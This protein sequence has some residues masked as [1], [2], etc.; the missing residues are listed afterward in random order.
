MIGVEGSVKVILSLGE[1]NERE[2]YYKGSHNG[3]EITALRRTVGDGI[4][5][6][7]QIDDSLIRSLGYDDIEVLR[8]KLGK[9]KFKRRGKTNAFF[10]LTMEL[11]T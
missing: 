1:V 7:L 2:A 5:N 4:K 8:Q 11:K 10:E 9:I 3:Y 6:L